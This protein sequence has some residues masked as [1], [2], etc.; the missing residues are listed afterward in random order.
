MIE[1]VLRV[2]L[3]CIWVTRLMT[4]HGATVNVV[5]QKDLDGGVLQSLVE[6]ELDEGDPAE[7]VAALE[8]NPDVVRVKA[9]VPSKGKIL[10]T[11]QVKDCQACHS[12]AESECF[13]T[14][15]TAMEGGGLVWHIIAPDRRTVEDL[16]GSLDEG[17]EAELLSIRSAK[18]KGML[19]DR[20][21]Q[22]ISLAYGLGY[23]EFP[24]RISLTSLAEKLGVA[25]STLSEILR[26]GEAKVLHA[27]FHG[28]MK[29]PR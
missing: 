14:D 25:K 27:Y 6:I 18:A 4:E 9:E 13:L 21:E 19:T 20:Q 28:L 2:H 5:E 16:M 7:V 10:A 12:L 26:T 24:K 15:A 11:L 8:G 1:A 23:F 17:P 22:V 29:Q 3:P